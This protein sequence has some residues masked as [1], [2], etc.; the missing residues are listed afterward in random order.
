MVHLERI[1]ELD[2]DHHEANKKIKILRKPSVFSDINEQIAQRVQLQ[3]EPERR[4]S[5]EDREA[6]LGEFLY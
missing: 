4:I 2:P 5:T 1:L 6:N 3:E